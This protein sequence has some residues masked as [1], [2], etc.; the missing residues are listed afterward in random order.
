MTPPI[1]A[2]EI[3]R[4][5]RAA[6]PGPWKVDKELSIVAPKAPVMTEGAVRIVIDEIPLH[7]DDDTRDFIASA[8]PQTLLTLIAALREAYEALE[9]YQACH[10]TPSGFPCHTDDTAEQTLRSIAEKVEG[11]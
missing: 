8:N 10:Y 1:N 7:M 4:L 2:A 6:T 9:H 11:L 3:E 5:A